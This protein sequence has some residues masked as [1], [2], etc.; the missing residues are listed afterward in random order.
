MPRLCMEN[1][2]YMT[3]PFGWL[4]TRCQVIK[5]TY[6]TYYGVDACMVKQQYIYIKKEYLKL[7]YRLI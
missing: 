5:K 1:G 2:R 7:F 6:A 4:I 3:G